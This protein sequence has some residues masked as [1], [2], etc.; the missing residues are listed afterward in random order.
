MLAA[1]QEEGFDYVLGTFDIDHGFDFNDS[2]VWASLLKLYR[3][4]EQA[5]PNLPKIPEFVT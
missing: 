1:A 3:E 4:V 5:D 2:L